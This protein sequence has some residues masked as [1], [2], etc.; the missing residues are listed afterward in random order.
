MPI[1]IITRGGT[2]GTDLELVQDNKDMT[3]R[4]TVNDGD[5]ACDTPMAATPSQDG[6]IIVMLNGRK[7]GVSITVGDVNKPCYFSADGGTTVKAMSNVALGDKLY[8]RQSV[9]GRNLNVLDIIDFIY[10]A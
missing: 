8:W 1:L 10:Q 5:L 3:A 6:Y 2:L 7:V 4:V 9:Y